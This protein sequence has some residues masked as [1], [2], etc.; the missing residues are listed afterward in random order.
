MADEQ[1]R[2][3]SAPQQRYL[4]TKRAATPEDL[5]QMGGYL[6]AAGYDK[7]AF[8]LSCETLART[9]ALAIVER[10]ENKQ[11]LRVEVRESGPVQAAW[12]M[13]F[14]DAKTAYCAEKRFLDVKWMALVR[15]AEKKVVNP[16]LVTQRR[17]VYMVEGVGALARVSDPSAFQNGAVLVHLV[18]MPNARQEPHRSLEVR[19]KDMAPE[20]VL[21]KEHIRTLL[22]RTEKFWSKR[23]HNAGETSLYRSSMEHCFYETLERLAETGVL[24]WDTSSSFTIKRLDEWYDAVKLFSGHC[25]PDA[26][27][28]WVRLLGWAST[29]NTVPPPAR[30]LVTK[31]YIT[32]ALC[33]TYRKLSWAERQDLDLFK[34]IVERS[35]L[36]KAS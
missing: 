13:F 26:A 22:V 29:D 24:K 6:R 32:A 17:K 16:T 8:Y 7:R 31:P 12:Q 20:R 28:A 5:A 19:C 21:A 27:I 33:L 4:D 10:A 25:M 15:D 18:N 3:L 14:E 36:P 2:P 34:Q 9:G 11:P 35:Y 30:S 23:V 1:H